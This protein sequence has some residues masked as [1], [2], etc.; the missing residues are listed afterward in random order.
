ML[1]RLWFGMYGFATLEVWFLDS[2]RLGADE[3]LCLGL[4]IETGFVLR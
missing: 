4:R 3:G 1:I 2:V